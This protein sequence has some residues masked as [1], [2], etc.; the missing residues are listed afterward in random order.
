MEG[1]FHVSR[2]LSEQNRVH[3]R[4]TPLHSRLSPLAVSLCLAFSLGAMPAFAQT[5]DD[6]P[7]G[8]NSS[9]SDDGPPLPDGLGDGP[10]LPD[11]LDGDGPALPDGLDGSSDSVEVG[12]TLEP[13][14]RR[15][16]VKDILEMSGFA[17]LRGGVRIQEDPNQDRV[18][19]GEMRVQMQLEKF[20]TDNFSFKTT[21]DFLIDG[22]PNIVQDISLE[23]GEGSIDLREAYVSFSPVSII[24]FKIGRQIATWGTG[25]LLFLNDLFPKGWNATLLGRDIAYL[26]APSD[27]I[28]TS[29]FLPWFDVDTFFVPRFDPDRY[30]SGRRAS[31]YNP[32]FGDLAGNQAVLQPNHPDRWFEDYEIH[33]R[34]S[35]VIDSAE[36]AFYGYRGFWKSPGG[37]SI[38]PMTG[39]PTPEFPALNAYGGSLRNILGKAITNLE[40]AYYDSSNDSTGDNPLV[41]NGQIRFLMGYERQVPELVSELTVSF[42]YYLELMLDYYEYRIAQDALNQ[43]GMVPVPFPIKDQF[44]NVLT[45]RIQKFLLNQNMTIN[46]YA[47]YSPSDEDGYIRPRID[48][49]FRGNWQGAIGGNIFFG[50]NNH[51]MFGQFQ[52]NSNVYLSL[53]RSY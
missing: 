20:F 30:I 2:L 44:R 24:D 32:F 10:E 15:K 28:K 8:D 27:A 33:A 43:S 17:E 52:N 47:L 21:A 29:F 35:K 25:D 38:D 7:T 13:L 11:G 6:T 23:R 45:M 19:L 40:I 50:E 51:T 42:Q 41:E 37:F 18:S 26:K 9:A 14:E 53:R 22:T 5:D 4:F 12:P 48:Y 46:V 34:L 36:L 1:P 3:S 49:K 16:L 31:Y 39:F